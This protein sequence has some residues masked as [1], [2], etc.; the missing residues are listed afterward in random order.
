MI[1]FWL[2][3]GAGAATITIGLFAGREI[4]SLRAQNARLIGRLNEKQLE[5]WMKG[6]GVNG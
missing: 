1:L 3:L 5:D 2:L 6:M 4:L